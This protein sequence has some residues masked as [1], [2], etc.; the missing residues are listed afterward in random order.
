MNT[1]KTNVKLLKEAQLGTGCREAVGGAGEGAGL[2][3]ETQ[4]HR[5]FW[6][7]SELLGRN[8][9][10][11]NWGQAPC[12]GPSGTLMKKLMLPENSDRKERRALTLTLVLPLQWTLAWDTS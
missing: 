10:P 1:L 6:T 12:P 7:I 8:S 5:G 4:V 9:I 11:P 2:G 3:T